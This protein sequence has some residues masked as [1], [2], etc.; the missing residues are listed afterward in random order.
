VLTPRE[1]VFRL[2]G[3]GD[4]T[5]DGAVEVPAAVVVVAAGVVPVAGVDVVAPLGDVSGEK[6]EPSAY[7]DRLMP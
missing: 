7:S 5:P 1:I 2:K 4:L 6:M 3:A